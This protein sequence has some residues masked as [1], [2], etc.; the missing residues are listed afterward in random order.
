MIFGIYQILS[1]KKASESVFS[2][3]FDLNPVA[4]SNRVGVVRNPYTMWL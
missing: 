1:M 4:R 2:E 3:V